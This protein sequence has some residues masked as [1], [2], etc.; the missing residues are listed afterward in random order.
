MT[1]TEQLNQVR[2]KKNS[3]KWQTTYLNKNRWMRHLASARNRA[4]KKGWH[5]SLTPA[6]IKELW[7]RDNAAA[8]SRP[9]IDRID[10]SLGYCYENCRFIELIE[11]IRLGNIGRPKSEH[12]IESARRN[13]IALNKKRAARILERNKILCQ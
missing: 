13:M 3:T 1:N 11:N 8:L 10:V 6:Q 2:A 9:S 4:K 7:D 5:F 12:E